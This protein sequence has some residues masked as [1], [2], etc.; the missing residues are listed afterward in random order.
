M[1]LMFQRVAHNYAKN[2]Y[3]PT[4]SETTL[5]ILN[6]IAPCEHGIMRILDP[7]SVE[8]TALAETKHVLGPE[9]CVAYGIEYDEERAWEAKELLDYCIHADIHDCIMGARS[10]GF[11][12]LNPP[13]GDTIANRR[14]FGEKTDRLEKVFYRMTNGLLQYGGVMALIVP[15]YSLDKE[16]SSL[17]A[18]HFHTVRV[19]ATPEQQFKQ[20]VVLGIKQR[21]G[22]IDT[23]IR[24]RLLAVGKMDTLPDEFPQIWPHEAYEVPASSSEPKFYAAR[25]DLRQLTNV[26]DNTRSL[27]DQMGLV[28]RY[29]STNHRRPVRKLSD[30]HLAL[31]LAAGQVSGC[32]EKND[33][34]K[35]V[36][37]GVTFKSKKTTEEQE[38]NSKGDL[39][40]TRRIQTDRF[41]PT[42]RALDFTEG[43]ETFGKCLT[44]K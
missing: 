22:Q 21:S 4:D 10:Y 1:G 28:F 14:G 9:R 3:Y 18:R 37:K 26:I 34:R 15:H 30:W 41:V 35:N 12:W 33:G 11:L 5:R 38:F 29:E 40:R 31:A 2:G 8:G 16:L 43:S 13:Y 17:I 20:I 25:I 42:I 39:T 27:W 24:D 19:F 36:I 32:V 23:E 7:C 6:S 44:I